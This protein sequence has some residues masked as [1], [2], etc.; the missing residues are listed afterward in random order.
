[1]YKK[2]LIPL[3]GSQFAESA[4]DHARAIAKVSSVEKVILLR[5]IEPL[6]VD[7]KD[8]IGAERAREAE[9][10]READAKKYLH[11]VAAELKKENIPV[12]TKLVVDGEPAEKIL[13]VAKDEKVDLITMSTHG[14]SGFQQWVFGSVA[15]RVLVHC[16]IPILMVVPGG[17]R[18]IT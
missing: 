13:E 3:D 1:M 5:V 18:N 10:K 14:R 11:K 9:L 12:E 15:H 6:I 7:V 4:L 8:F 16:S 17:G 2:I